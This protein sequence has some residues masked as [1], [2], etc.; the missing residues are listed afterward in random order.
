[1][2]GDILNEKIHLKDIDVKIK[3]GDLVYIV[4]DAGSGKT[5]LLNAM[6]GEMISISSRKIE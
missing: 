3:Q 4:G 2:S 6:L 5:S 1:M